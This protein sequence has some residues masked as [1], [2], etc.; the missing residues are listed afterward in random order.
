MLDQLRSCTHYFGAPIL[1]GYSRL[2]IAKRC[3]WIET[4][5]CPGWRETREQAGQYRNDHADE[6]QADRE[7]N[8]KRGESF[9]DPEAHQICECEPDKSTEQT[10]RRRF[11]EELQQDCS[12]SRAER[13]AR[14]DFFGALF[15]ADECDI[16]DPNR[17]DKKR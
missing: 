11:D 8:R 6:H 14:S 2:F 5:R 16:H 9:A 17:A 12:P 3:N 4:R 1:Q 7:M 10:K 15:Y 13:L